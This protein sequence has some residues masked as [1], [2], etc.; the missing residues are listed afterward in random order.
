MSNYSKLDTNKIE[1]KNIFAP[2]LFAPNLS[3]T[4]L[5]TYPIY[6]NLIINTNLEN[7]DIIK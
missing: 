6:D 5:N 7:K 4:F 2:N 1:E 3:S